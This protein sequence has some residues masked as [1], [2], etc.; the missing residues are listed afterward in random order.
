M[1]EDRITQQDSIP[2]ARVE[3]L[4]YEQQIIGEWVEQDALVILGSGL[5]WQRLLAVLLRLHHHQRVS[6]SHEPIANLIA[7]F[8]TN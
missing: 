3:L 4:P 2:P 5:G 7:S 8:P 6:N 1:Q